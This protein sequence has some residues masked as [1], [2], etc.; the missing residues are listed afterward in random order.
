MSARRNVACDCHTGWEQ[1]TE[2]YRQHA[3]YLPALQRAAQMHRLHRMKGVMFSHFD[4]LLNVRSLEQVPSLRVPWVLEN[5]YKSTP[6]HVDGQGP[7]EV[8]YQPACFG[9][10]RPVPESPHRSLR[11]PHDDPRCSPRRAR[12]YPLRIEY[13][14]AKRVREDVVYGWRSIPYWRRGYAHRTVGA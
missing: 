8:P 10:L 13:K 5:G 3:L 4:M 2:S 6:A 14:S 11:G 12:C 1:V 7:G 9:V